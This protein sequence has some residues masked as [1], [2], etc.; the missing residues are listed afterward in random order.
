VNHFPG[1]EQLCRKKNLARHL[2]AMRRAATDAYRFF[3]F[4]WV[5]PQ[6]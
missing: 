4:T 5:L 2:N 3:P 6:E 1:I